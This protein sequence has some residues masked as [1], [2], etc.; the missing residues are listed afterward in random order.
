MKEKADFFNLYNHGFVRVAVGTPEV[1]VADPAFN[2]VRT[3]ELMTKA[4]REQAILAL[5]PELGL[6]S[7]SCEDL[8]HQQVLLDS[9][10]EALK[11]ILQASEALNLIAVV[12]VP[13]QVDHL[14]FNC[15]IVLHRGKILGIVPKTFLPNYREFYE[16]RQFAPADAAHHTTVEV[17]GQRGFSF[18]PKKS[19]ALLFL[20][21]SARTSGYPFRPP[22]LPR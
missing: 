18:N 14:L 2:A 20:S 10:L 6:S 8:F 12:G 7:Y 13:L 9:A 4:E 17:I 11:A 21:R 19:R 3:I 5:F 1:R 22:A 16:Y 15:A